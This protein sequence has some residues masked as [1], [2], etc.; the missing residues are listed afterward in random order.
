MPD[1]TKTLDERV[2]DLETIYTD[3]PEILNLRFDRLN[4]QASETTA[5]LGLMDRQFATLTRD[6]R[7][8]RSGMTAQMR[9]LIDEQRKQ[10]EK[11]D[12]LEGDV[13]TLKADVSTLKADVST[14]K[15]DVSTLKADVGSIKTTLS[16]ILAIVKK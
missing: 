3:L 6:V 13:S 2:A 15:A 7:D 5:R 11:L 16:E 12:R 9:L 1:L 8:L 10:G 14:L 4:A